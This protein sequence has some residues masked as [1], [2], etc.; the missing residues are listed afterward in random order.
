MDKRFVDLNVLKCEVLYLF[1]ITIL[2]LESK[3][4]GAIK[5]NIF[6]AIYRSG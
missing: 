5:E 2:L 3:F 4:S 6:V 1:G